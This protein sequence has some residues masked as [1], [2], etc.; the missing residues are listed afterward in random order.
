MWCI[1]PVWIERRYIEHQAKTASQIFHRYP[2][3]DVA[4]AAWFKL[5]SY[6]L[7]CIRTAVES[8]RLNINS[9]EAMEAVGV[10][11]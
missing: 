4:L 1:D 5:K 6:E 8:L 10:N 9:R 3:E 7:T 2:M 11:G